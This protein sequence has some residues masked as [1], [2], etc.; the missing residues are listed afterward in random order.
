[1]EGLLLAMVPRSKYLSIVR[2]GPAMAG[3]LLILAMVLSNLPMVGS[4]LVPATVRSRCLWVVP[5]NPA[6]VG[7]LLRMLISRNPSRLIAGSLRPINERS[8]RVQ[9]E[10]IPLDSSSLTLEL[11]G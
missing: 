10:F 3:S 4:H 6:L 8:G 2:L 11:S 7:L 1:M 9:I 5:T